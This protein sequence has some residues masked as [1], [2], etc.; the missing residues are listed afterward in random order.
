MVLAALIES[1]YSL[2]LRSAATRYT[3]NLS[4]SLKMSAAS[5]FYRFASD[6]EGGIFGFGGCSHDGSNFK[7]GRIY[8][9]G[10]GDILFECKL[11]I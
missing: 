10:L 7:Y 1:N 3:L 11:K 2:L 5:F 8:L 4:V 6:G 9:H